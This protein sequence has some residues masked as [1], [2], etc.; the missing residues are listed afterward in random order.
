MISFPLTWHLVTATSA[1]IAIAAIASH[2]FPTPVSAEAVLPVAITNIS[3][4]TSTY[5]ND[6][7]GFSLT[8]P[9]DLAARE[10]DEGGGTKSIVFRNDD[11]LMGFQMF[12]TP[13]SE[14]F[15][16]TTSLAAEFPTLQIT[17]PKKVTVGTGTPA[18]AFESEAPDLGASHE[19]WFLHGGYLFDVTTYPD[20]SDWLAH[21]FGSLRF[22]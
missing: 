18:L 22:Y 1:G 12:I 15:I 8:Y 21:I 5:K 10:Y 14:A 20:Q 3:T 4:T 7:Y 17:D 9:S 11:A 16:S 19:L 2:P 6:V 13:D